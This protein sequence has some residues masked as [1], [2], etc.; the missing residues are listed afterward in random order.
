[1][2]VLALLCRGWCLQT[3][4]AQFAA[5]HPSSL[6]HTFATREC[7]Q[8]R[9]S[10]DRRTRTLYPAFDAHCTRGSWRDIYR[11]SRSAPKF[12]HRFSY[13]VFV[14]ASAYFNHLSPTSR[15]TKRKDRVPTG[16]YERETD[17]SRMII[18]ISTEDSSQLRVFCV[19]FLRNLT[20]HF[21]SYN[22]WYQPHKR[23]LF[24]Y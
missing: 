17:E 1:M 6:K 14:M 24:L 21:Y 13:D 20:Q 2:P 8:I 19:M 15:I 4:A 12:A 23:L 18:G 16:F 3:D 5:V 22:S 10:H 7:F 11:K 9:I